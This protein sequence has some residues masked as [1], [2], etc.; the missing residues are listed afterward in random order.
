MGRDQSAVGGGESH[1]TEHDRSAYRPADY[2][3]I[4]SIPEFLHQIYEKSLK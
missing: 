2:S 4:I 1:L 3:R